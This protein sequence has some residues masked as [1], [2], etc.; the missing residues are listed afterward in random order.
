MAKYTSFHFSPLNNRSMLMPRIPK[1]TK[2]APARMMRTPPSEIVPIDPAHPYAQPNT[3]LFLR[4]ADMG[5]HRRAYA[6]YVAHD[7]PSKG[8]AALIF[9]DSGVK[10]EAF[11]RSGHWIA[12]AEKHHMA[13]IVLESEAWDIEDI[14]SEFDYAQKIVDLEYLARVTV[15]IC[16]AFIYPIGFGKGAAVATAFA[17]TFSATY[18]AFAADGDCAVDP[19]LLEV[20]RGLPSDGID[21]LKKTDV[22]LPGFIIDRSGKAEATATYMREII[23]SRDEGLSNGF[24]QVYLEQPRRGAYFVNDQPISQVWIADAM[25]VGGM[26]REALDEKMLEF[27]LRYA[28]WGG[29]GNNHLRPRRSLEEVG[30]ERVH[31]EI[32]GLDRYWDVYVPSCYRP[33]DG[34]TYPLVVAIHGYSCNSEYFEQTSDWYRLGEERGFFVVFPSAYPQGGVLARLQLPRWACGTLKRE[35]DISEIPYFEALLDSVTST[36]AIDASRIYAV[37]H[38]NGGM[39]VQ[40]LMRS[41]PERFAAFSPTGSLGAMQPG[42]VEPFVNDHQR[43][44]WFMIGEYDLF[45][46]DLSE[47][48]V[49]WD[50]LAACCNA[51]RMVMQPDNWYDNGAYHTLVMYDNAHAPMVQFTVI[52]NCPH[53]YTAEMAQLTWDTFL[54]HFTREPDGTVKYHG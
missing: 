9:P 40:D 31:R 1:G 34:K 42:G 4:E 8:P 17:L 6:I 30:V 19:E 27:V 18:P 5:T 47:G 51:N 53:T 12:L 14:S 41:M 49:A 54:C 25:S 7:M 32:D 20:L 36:Y 29:F 39:M 13:L 37:G 52:R 16:E 24:A 35:G 50:T 43:P 2:Y 44:V 48:S 15:D 23:R 3:G 46:G 33:G 10:A 45:S 11:L 26:S 28:R 38:S 22:A 21:T